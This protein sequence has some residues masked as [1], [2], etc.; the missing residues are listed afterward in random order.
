MNFDQKIFI[1]SADLTVKKIDP[2][3]EE[4]ILDVKDLAISGIHETELDLPLNYSLDA[5]IE[6]FGAKLTV[7]LPPK[8]SNSYLINISYS[9]SPNASGLQWLSPE[10]TVGKEHPYVFSQFQAIHARS[11]VPCQ[12]TPGVKV[13]YSALVSEI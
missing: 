13:T 8:Q 6:G 11:F 12:D 1:G 10:Q 9:T 2:A 3:A 5:P 7:R 4:V